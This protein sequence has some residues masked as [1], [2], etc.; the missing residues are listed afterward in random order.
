MSEAK[1]LKDKFGRL[2][3]RVE[4]KDNEWLAYSDHT[5]E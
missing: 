5:G 1:L 3:G 4:D 2:I